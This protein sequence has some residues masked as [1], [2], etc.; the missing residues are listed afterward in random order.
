[1]KH[2]APTSV[3]G[4]IGRL[5]AFAT[6]VLGCE[7]PEPDIDVIV[8]TCDQPDALPTPTADVPAESGTAPRPRPAPPPS[9]DTLPLLEVVDFEIAHE[10][11]PD[12]GEASIADL[13]W[14]SNSTPR[15]GRVE[16]TT[17]TGRGATLSVVLDGRLSMAVVAGEGPRPAPFSESAPRMFDRRPNAHR[18]PVV[19]YVEPLALLDASAADFLLLSASVTSLRGR[20]DAEACTGCVAALDDLGWAWLNVLRSKC[21]GALGPENATACSEDIWDPGSLDW[22]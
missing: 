9:D 13:R 22:R 8:D 1:M 6:V 15:R 20:L 10:R 16:L 14:R 18:G 4:R 19:A 7:Q 17:L 2:H 21:R 11:A 5:V 3:G 12:G